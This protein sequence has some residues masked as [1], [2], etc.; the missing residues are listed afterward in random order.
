M[1]TQ[2]MVMKKFK[3]PLVLEERDIGLS[4]QYDIIVRI[5]A[6][7]VC[8]SDVHMWKGADP[9]TPLSL[10]LGHEGVGY[11]EDMSGEKKDIFGKSLK[12]GDLVIWDRGV[13]CGKCY[14]C[15]VKKEASLCPNRTVYG[16]VRDGCYSSHL[17]LLKGTNLIKIETDIDPAVLVPA[18]CSGAT[19]AHTTEL[20]DI[21]PA[22]SVLIIGPG[23]VGLYTAAL[24]KERGAYPI[25]MQGMTVDK[26]RLEFSKKFGVDE[27]IVVDDTTP[28][29]RLEII[30]S[31][32]N[33][34]GA[35]AVIDC[36]GIS[37]AINEGLKMVARGGVFSV[38]GIATPVGKT[39][40]SF[41]EDVALKNVS[42]QG[43]WVSDTN[44]LYQCVK[45]VESKRYPF[46]DFI[47]HRFKLE[48]ADKAFEAVD[49]RKAIKAVLIP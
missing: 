31:H 48:E 5:A 1:K 28:E 39:E 11:I 26:E 13:T 45:L 20:C 4:E 33:G 30:K 24:A 15:T 35:D 37:K 3:K 49:S 21:K 46:G 10:V 44:H 14:Y 41:Y 6:A 47:T 43:V 8:G 19:S 34:F 25:I 2:S 12:K 9:R 22:Q 18:S 29:E 42:I 27:T 40:I 36:T 38:P 32:T 7:G 16:I 23:P 17:A